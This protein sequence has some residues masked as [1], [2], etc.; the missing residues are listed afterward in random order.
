MDKSQGPHVIGCQESRV[1]CDS[2]MNC[3]EIDSLGQSFFSTDVNRSASEAAVLNLLQLSMTNSAMSAQGL[4]TIGL[5]AEK[6]HRGAVSI[7]L[8]DNHWHTE[9]R[10]FWHASLARLQAGV[11]D[12]ARG[13]NG[14]RARYQEVYPGLLTAACSSV[15]FQTVGWKNI[16]LLQLVSLSCCLFLLWISTIT[17]KGHVLLIWFYG[18]L[19]KPLACRV[20]ELVE[21]SID[22][23][24]NTSAK[25][26][27][28]SW[29]WKPPSR[30]PHTST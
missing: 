24:A 16:N 14:G 12:V 9:I 10:H 15:K 4:S 8:A 22:L 17:F 25:I 20:F 19:I 28:L 1:F 5:L 26:Q 27:H 29:K 21:N 13:K 3:F 6:Y 18:L 7:A 23:I 2:T 30:N 11:V